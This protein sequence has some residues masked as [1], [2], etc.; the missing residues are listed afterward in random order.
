MQLAKSLHPKI[1]ATSVFTANDKAFV[2]VNRIMLEGLKDGVAPGMVLLVG[3][4]GEVVYHNSF[5]A[6]CLKSDKDDAANIM[7]TDTVFD[8]ASVT[9]SVITTTI[10]MKLIESGKL[11]LSDKVVRYIQGFG[12]LGKSP[13]SIEHLITHTSGLPAWMPFYEDLVKAHS[14]ARLGVLTSRGARDYI[15]NCILRLSPK[16]EPGTKQVYS[17]LGVILLG[18]IIEMLTGLTLDKAAQ[19][20]VMHPLGMRSSSYIDLSMIKRRGIHPVTDLIAPT[21]DCPWRK[22]VLCGEVHDDNAWVMGGISGHSGLF[23]TSRDLHLVAKE[24][25]LAQRG[26]SS[27]LKKETVDTFF[28]YPRLL[29]PE[30]KIPDVKISETRI[31]GWRYGWDSISRDNGMIESNLSESSVGVCG[32]TGC[33]VWIDPQR[34]L[35]VILMTNRIHPSRSNKK[36][37]TFRSELHSAIIDAIAG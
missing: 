20:M 13:I 11:N 34:G 33:S 25:V 8:V 23:S 32:F 26:Q 7:S 36:I 30:Q 19:R 12:V 24:L 28:R 9:G 1:S 5:G 17:D 27:F 18:H 14:G 16:T 31:E 6:R 21:E 10:L 2:D 37:I 35:D 3:I 22:R 29:Q 15:L 4:G